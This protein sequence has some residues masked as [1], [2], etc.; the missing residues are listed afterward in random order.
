MA[1]RGLVT[2]PVSTPVSHKPRLTF[3]AVKWIPKRP[4][5]RCTK[6]SMTDA[7]ILFC[8]LRR[9]VGTCTHKRIPRTFKRNSEQA[10]V[11]RHCPCSCCF[12]G[13]RL[14]TGIKKKKNNNKKKQTQMTNIVGMVR[15]RRVEMTPTSV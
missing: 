6:I 15:I 13:A 10:T 3:L 11:S 5:G 8:S 12:A 7:S 14:A 2:V 4:A 9:Q 1:P